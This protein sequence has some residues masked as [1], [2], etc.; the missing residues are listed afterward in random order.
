MDLNSRYPALSD[1]RAR[2]KRRLPLF[3]WEYL[4]SGTG[5]EATKA[6]N[7]SQLDCVR[8]MPSVLHGEFEPDVSVELLG[9]H[10]ALPVGIAP[11]GMSGLI[12]P[13]AERLLAKASADLGIPYTLST[14]ASQ[15]PEDVAPHLGENA[16]FQMYPPRDPEIRSDMLNRARA[17]GFDVLVLTVDVPVGSR[18]ERQA[19]S[20]LTQPPR[21]T[22]RLMAQV[23]QCPVWA[24][25]MAQRGMPRMRMIDDYAGET[26]GLP[27]N[28]HAG[29]LLRTSPDWDYLRWLR[30]AWEGPMV[31]KGVLRAEDAKQLQAEGM[32]AIWIS[33]HGGRQFDAAPATIEVLPSI[34]AATDLPIILDGGI[35][36]GLDILRAIALGADFV[37]LGRAW[38]YA[39]AALGAGGP[40]HLAHILRADLEANMGQLGTARLQE[41]RQRIIPDG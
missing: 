13:D 20:G 17:A 12:W 4:D 28:K 36:G 22:P 15:T 29:Y 31:V 3:V 19:R 26:K 10:M 24:M 8:L 38:H 9:Q 5:V 7:R 37:M 1:L 2:A 34:R 39:L 41:V 32:D 16:W 27:S 23:A 14:V 33:N 40:N 11:V 6:R 21:L 18:R 35:E 25:G 30:D